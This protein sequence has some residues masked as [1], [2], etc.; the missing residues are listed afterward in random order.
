MKNIYD[1]SIQNQTAKER[2]TL[3]SDSG[4]EYDVSFVPAII[5]RTYYVRWAEYNKDMVVEL[6]KFIDV[7]KKA[8]E[9]GIITEED[10]ATINSYSD[11]AKEAAQC[12]LDLIVFTMKSNGYKDFDEDELL[13]NFSQKSIAFAINFIMGLEDKKKVKKSP[14]TKKAN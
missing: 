12:G 6:H 14:R 8:T 2:R 5:N 1:L 9:G 10:M 13:N 7:Q 3:I 11:L 4:K